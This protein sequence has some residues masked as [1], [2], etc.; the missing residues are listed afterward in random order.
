[1]EIF[2]FVRQLLKVGGSLFHDQIQVHVEVANFS[3]RRFSVVHLFFG[4]AGVGHF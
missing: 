4:F 1:M 2:D 3:T